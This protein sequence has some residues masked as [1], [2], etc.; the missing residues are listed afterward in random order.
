MME[1]FI[2]ECC[3]V[4]E[5]FKV[6]AKEIYDRY[7]EWCDMGRQ[8]KV[9]SYQKSSLRRKDITLDLFIVV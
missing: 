4:G 6:E 3:E 2:E 8:K 9:M 7:V 1:M 5:W